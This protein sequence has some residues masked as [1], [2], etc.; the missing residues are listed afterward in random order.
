MAQWLTNPTRNHEVEG[1]IPGLA[2]WVED[3]VLLW[4]GLQTLLRS[5]IAVTVAQAGGYS[6]DLTPSLGASKCRGSSPR[7]GKKTK[8]NPKKQNNFL[9]MQEQDCLEKSWLLDV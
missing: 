9:S 4:C 3:L 1:S 6:S 7:K 8:K 5:L 2:Q